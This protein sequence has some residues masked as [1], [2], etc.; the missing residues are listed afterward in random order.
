MGKR[1]QRPT[2]THDSVIV[3]SEE[4]VTSRCSTRAAKAA[5]ATIVIRTLTSAGIALRCASN[6]H[7]PVISK[8]LAKYPPLYIPTNESGFQYRNT[9]TA[10]SE[11]SVTSRNARNIEN[12]A[13]ALTRLLAATKVFSVCRLRAPTASRTN[14]PASSRIPA[15]PKVAPTHGARDGTPASDANPSVFAAQSCAARITRPSNRTL[16]CVARGTSRYSPVPPA[17]SPIKS[18]VNSR[19]PRGS[20]AALIASVCGGNG[21]GFVYGSNSNGTPY[22]T[23]MGAG[24]I[25]ITPATPTRAATRIAIAPPIE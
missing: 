1:A 4:P 19:M 20:N 5:P 25:A 21:G 13:V 12:P 8:K 24:E 22:P 7:K 10:N 2:E 17:L 16:T 9:I 15:N 18:R 6:K 23:R 14:G 11:A 3:Q